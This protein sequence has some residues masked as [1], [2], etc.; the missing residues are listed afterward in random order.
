[1]NDLCMIFHTSSGVAVQ[2]ASDQH[3]FVGLS[4]GFINDLINPLEIAAALEDGVKSLRSAGL[5]V[6]APIFAAGHSLAGETY[7]FIY[8]IIIILSTS[9]IIF[10]DL[11]FTIIKF[12]Q[13]QI[14][15][16]DILQYI[17]ILM[18]IMITKI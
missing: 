3:L 16:Q 12:F 1:M 10:L 13:R 17:C 5:P 11:L 15:I 9:F 18:I 7:A 2:E 8:D 14:I 6:D 4:G